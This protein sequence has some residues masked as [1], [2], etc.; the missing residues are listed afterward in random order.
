V[1]SAAM[2]RAGITASWSGGGGEVGKD[3]D[4]QLTGQLIDDA[5]LPLLDVFP[6]PTT[7]EVEATYLQSAEMLRA[8]GILSAHIAWM[9]VELMPMLESLRDRAGLRLRLCLMMDGNDANLHTILERGPVSDPWLSSRAVKFFADGAL[10]SQGAHL[11]DGYSSGKHGLVLETPARLDERCATLAAQG[12]QVCVHAIGDAAVRQT[13]ASFSQMTPAQRQATRPRVEHAQMCTASDIARFAE[14]A[15]IAS[16]QPIHMR[17]DA[18]WA[19]EIL[20]EAQL[21]R[22]FPWRRLAVMTR[23]AGGS[24]YPIEDPNPWHSISVALSRRSRDGRVFRLN[25]ALTA[26]QVLDAYTA[27]AAYAAH[28]EHDLGELNVGFVAD[29]IAPSVDPFEASPEA[30]WDTTVQVFSAK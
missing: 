19:D 4:G 15:A 21:G 3:V 30:I 8:H 14:L 20:N 10:G 6:D 25:D 24:D 23:L 29:V 9:P 12:W 5:M 7:A 13:L 17:S 27:G 1:N 26:T 2:R 16:I 28:W 18:A 11:I 22:L